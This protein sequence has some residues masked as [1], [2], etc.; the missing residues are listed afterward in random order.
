MST[1]IH[2]YGK[3]DILVVRTQKLEVQ[4]IKF[5]FAWQSSTAD[6][7]KI[8]QCEDKIQ[9][10][11]DWIMSSQFAIDREE[12]VYADDDIF[13]ENSP[14]GTKI[15]NDGKEHIALFDEWLDMCNENGYGVYFEAW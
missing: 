8:M 10:Y 14:I 12:H 5:K 6:T 13:H 1:N 3:R 4:T 9:A 11:K 7:R 2:I 15:V